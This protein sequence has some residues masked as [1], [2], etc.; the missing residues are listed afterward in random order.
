LFDSKRDAPPTLLPRKGPRTKTAPDADDNEPFFN[1]YRLAAEGRGQPLARRA[2]GCVSKNHKHHSQNLTEGLA[3]SDP[4]DL[5]RDIEEGKQFALSLGMSPEQVA[6][7]YDA[8]EESSAPSP[9][10][11]S[12]HTRKPMSKYRV[13]FLVWWTILV[14]FIAIFVYANWDIVPSGSATFNVLLIL[15]ISSAISWMG[16]PRPAQRCS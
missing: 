13:A 14:L 6:T 4:A 16:R 9:Q 3:M 2:A 11:L 5:Q 10:S 1:L 7:L 12:P 15:A 8:P